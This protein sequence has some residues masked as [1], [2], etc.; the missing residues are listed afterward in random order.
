MISVSY[1]KGIINNQWTQDISPKPGLLSFKQGFS[2][3][4]VEIV[5]F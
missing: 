4:K 5:K 1:L 2:H 3:R